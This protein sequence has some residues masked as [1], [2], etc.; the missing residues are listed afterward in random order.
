MVKEVVRLTS[1]GTRRKAS[2]SSSRSSRTVM[3]IYD[4][5]YYRRDGP[6]YLGSFLERGT[7]CKWLI[8]INVVV[9]ILQMLTRVP[10]DLPRGGIRFDDGFFTAALDLDVGAVLRGQVWRLLT[11]AFLHSTN[12]LPLHLLFNMLFL[13]WFGTDVEDLYGP[14][15]FLAI[16]LVGAVAG[17]VLFTLTGIATGSPGVAI[18]ASGAVVTVLVLCACHFPTRI[19][20][21]MWVIPMPLW[22]Y[23]IVAVALDAYVMLGQIHNGVAVACHLGG[24]AF[25]FAYY[26]ANIRLT[27][28]LPNL[29]NWQQRRKQPRLRVYREDE[30]DADKK[31]PQAVTVAA[32]AAAPSSLDDEQLEAKMDAVLEKISRVGK[33]NLTESEREV[34]MRAS[35]RLKKRRS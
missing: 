12:G 21:F 29:R 14:R 15:E 8:G 35:E 27:N 33:D 10:V 25:G 22:I 34:L 4:R 2:A 6:S 7:V 19:M 13:W 5:D 18:G 16:Y 26:K 11:Y 17:G 1:E 3:G 23:V 32:P 30:D 24:A 28:L 31:R 9:F 20:Y